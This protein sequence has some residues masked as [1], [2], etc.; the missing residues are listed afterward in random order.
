MN[1]RTCRSF[2]H[3]V[4][5]GMCFPFWGCTRCALLKRQGQY[6]AALSILYHDFPFQKCKRTLRFFCPASVCYSRRSSFQVAFL[7]GTLW[8]SWQLVCSGL[9]TK[10][11]R[12]D[13]S[14]DPMVASFNLLSQ[15]RA[16]PPCELV[17]ENRCP[18]EG[19]GTAS[20]TF[21]A[22]RNLL[23]LLWVLYTWQVCNAVM[24][25]Q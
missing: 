22:F 2:R 21:L 3:S 6:Q 14:L 9:P 1:L 4:L 13:T 12:T 5:E 10:F 18:R 23:K 24:W 20:Y 17:D 25:L 8:F 7:L 19:V 15:D 16:Q 11:W